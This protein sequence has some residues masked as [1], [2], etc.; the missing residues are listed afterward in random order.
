MGQLERI[1]RAHSI[2]VLSIAFLSSACGDER[3]GATSAAGSSRPESTEGSKTKP[4]FGEPA[5]V[6]MEAEGGLRYEMAIAL[7]GTPVGPV[8]E[9]VSTS[10]HK[11]LASCPDVL[12]SLKENAIVSVRFNV[13]AGQVQR[14]DDSS[15]TSDECLSR[16][17]IRSGLSTEASFDAWVQLR[18]PPG[19]P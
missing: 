5:L 4:Q 7:S 16:S 9:A 11:A 3:P 15:G 8:V 6:R 14:A 17:L 10:V 2:A 1:V 19:G 18:L 13:A 12:A